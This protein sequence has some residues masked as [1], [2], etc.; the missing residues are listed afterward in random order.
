MYK[1]YNIMFWYKSPLL[2]QPSA[3]RIFN[4]F[5]DRLNATPKLPKYVLIFPDE[6]IIRTMKHLDFRIM[7]MLEEQLKWLFDQLNKYS[8]HRCDD[9]RAMR[10]GAFEHYYT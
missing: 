5:I 1:Q 10:I 6:D 4:S 3:V 2:P 7:T 8:T 9:L